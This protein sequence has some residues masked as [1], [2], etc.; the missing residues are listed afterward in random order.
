MGNFTC[1]V[2]FR[3]LSHLVN[4]VL[5]LFLVISLTFCIVMAHLLCRNWLRAKKKMLL[6]TT[7]NLIVLLGLLHKLKK[8]K[9]VHT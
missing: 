4:K 7:L 1:L 5:L 3:T 9:E 8:L 6:E 2:C